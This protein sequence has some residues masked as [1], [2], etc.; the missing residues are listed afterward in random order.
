MIV[1]ASMIIK[2]LLYVFLGIMKNNNITVMQYLS[3]GRLVLDKGNFLHKYLLGLL[4]ECVWDI[5][6]LI[7]QVWRKCENL[8]FCRKIEHT[9]NTKL[10]MCFLHWWNKI[11]TIIVTKYNKKYAG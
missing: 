7:L 1:R 10:I 2:V 5:V 9:K 6:T 11:T 4:T 8:R 3:N